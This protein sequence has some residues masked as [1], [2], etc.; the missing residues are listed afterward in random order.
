M[1]TVTALDGR[2]AVHID[3]IVRDALARRDF[4]PVRLLVAADYAAVLDR[5]AP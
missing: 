1:T 3:R 2:G 5:S 4:N